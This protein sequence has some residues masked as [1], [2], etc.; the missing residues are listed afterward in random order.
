[1][2]L[3]PASD[4]R[5]GIMDEVHAQELFRLVDSNRIHLRQWLP[6][7]DSQKNTA[8]SLQFIRVTRDQFR[9]KE[10]MTMG[11]WYQDSLCGVI[12]YHRIDWM[13]RS[14]MI[15][16]WISSDR[17]GKGIMTEACRELVDYGFSRLGLHRVEIRCAIGNQRSRAI[18]ERLG[19]VN[20]GIAR[21]GEWLYDRYVDL[22]V[23]SMLAPEW[24]KTQH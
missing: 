14:S 3:T 2:L 7:L 20:E 23:Y 16:Y 15:G 10:S 18:P 21:Q 13:N 22:V 5:L 12:G 4:I 11:V 1:M 19:F 6:W 24:K 17:Q 9:N 8:D